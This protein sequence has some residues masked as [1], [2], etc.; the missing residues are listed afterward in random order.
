MPVDDELDIETDP[1]LDQHFLSNPAKL[2]LLVEAAEIRPTDHVVEVGAGIGTVAEHVPVCQ[3][4]T[5][6]EYD[7]ALTPHLRKRLPHA[8]VI[9]GDALV[10][11]PTVR[12]DVLVSNLP[13]KLTPALVELLPRLGFRV[14]LVTAPSI[15]SLAP[16]EDSFMLEVIVALEPDDFRPRQAGRAEIVRVRRSVGR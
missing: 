13:S 12:C 10:V 16:L 11:L 15:D 14:A 3:S 1:D 5:V 7:I 2:A 6:I 8:Q 4:L 9:Q